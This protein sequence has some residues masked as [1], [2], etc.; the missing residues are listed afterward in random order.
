MK[1]R[2]KPEMD[3]PAI[4]KTSRPGVPGRVEG[5]G[6][7]SID[8]G[9]LCTMESES[10][11]Y[12]FTYIPLYSSTQMSRKGPKVFE[13]SQNGSPLG[14]KM[15]EHSAYVPLRTWLQ[16]RFTALDG[17]KFTVWTEHSV[18]AVHFGITSQIHSLRADER[19]KGS[20]PTCPGRAS[21]SGCRVRVD[22][23]IL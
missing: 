8:S 9:L 11:T 10:N 21:L 5:V 7:V 3:R 18:R 15:D 6:F 16:K 2:T 12:T 13:P 19:E 20:L 14:Q 1:L 4:L 17:C 22:R 23:D